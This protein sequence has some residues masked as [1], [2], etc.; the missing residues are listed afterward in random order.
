MHGG[1]VRKYG[2]IGKYSSGDSQD[3]IL[4]QGH[5]SN[6]PDRRKTDNRSFIGL[7]DH[8]FFQLKNSK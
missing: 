2:Q 6:S 8:R 7:P 3:L 5:P 4:S 1:Q